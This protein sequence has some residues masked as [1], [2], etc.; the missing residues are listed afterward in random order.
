MSL[1]TMLH[2]A[3]N[4]MVDAMYAMVDAMYAMVDAMQCCASE[5]GYLTVHDSACLYRVM[6][7]EVTWPVMSMNDIILS[8]LLCLQ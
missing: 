5:R 7:S 6:H 1:N 8:C 3:M 4:V 2:D